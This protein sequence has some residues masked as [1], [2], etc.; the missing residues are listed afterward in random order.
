M[1][2]TKVCSR[3][4]DAEAADRGARRGPW[5]QPVAASR[6]GD[7]G[8][9]GECEKA[10]A[11]EKNHPSFSKKRWCQ[12]TQTHS[13]PVWSIA[14]AQSSSWRGRSVRTINRQ[15]ARSAQFKRFAAKIR[16]AHRFLP[17]VEI[18]GSGR[19]QNG[20]AVRIGQTR[21]WPH[22][23][24]EAMRIC[25]RFPSARMAAPGESQSCC[26]R[27]R[28]RSVEAGCRRL[29]RRGLQPAPCGTWE[30]QS[31]LPPPHASEPSSGRTWASVEQGGETSR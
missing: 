2:R 4:R 12:S 19:I 24:L 30:T 20:H 14:P 17:I 3:F 10:A 16:R 25:R 28:L 26:R 31:R 23:G 8:N 5:P 7:I 22:L 21:A 9:G 18:D 13:Y 29:H 27:P 6:G 1:A 15:F 11:S